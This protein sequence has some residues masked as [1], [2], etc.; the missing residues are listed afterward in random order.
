MYG[1]LCFKKL[2]AEGTSL[3]TIRWM[4]LLPSNQRSVTIESPISG[5]RL[6]DWSSKW[7]SGWTFHRERLNLIQSSFLIWPS[8]ALLYDPN[9]LDWKQRG[10]DFSRNW[11]RRR[12]IEILRKKVFVAAR[13]MQ[14]TF[15][16]PVLSLFKP[17]SVPGSSAKAYI[18]L[19]FI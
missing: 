3:F 4:C 11:L 5:G 6:V 17:V 9:Q 2:L 13:L 12:K 1:L 16:V 7:I 18:N 14:K 8:R 15:L 10:K 19:L